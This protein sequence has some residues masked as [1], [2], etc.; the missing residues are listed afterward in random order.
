MDN[1]NNYDLYKN[2]LD[3]NTNKNSV[4]INDAQN[5]SESASQRLSNSITEAEI[6]LF[7]SF[8]NVSFLADIIEDSIIV[9]G[10]DGKE[11]EE[12]ILRRTQFLERLN[13]TLEGDSVLFKKVRETYPSFGTEMDKKVDLTDFAHYSDVKTKFRRLISRINSTPVSKTKDAIIYENNV[14][15]DLEIPISE[16]NELL[17]DISKCI[18]SMDFNRACEIEKTFVQREI[19]I[20]KAMAAE[21]SVEDDV[22]IGMSRLEKENDD[23]IKKVNTYKDYYTGKLN[24][25]PKKY[26]DDDYRY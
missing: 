2:Y 10:D 7:D 13:T 21:K 16:Y 6:K 19:D 1:H 3:R 15:V 5:T 11:T 26:H 24:P 14:R 4:P 17:N 9:V 22:A 12:S 8:P 25:D 18:D 23:E 20:F